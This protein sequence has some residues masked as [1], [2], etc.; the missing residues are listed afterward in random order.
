MKVKSECGDQQQQLPCRGYILGT[1]LNSLVCSHN[2]PEALDGES[3][4]MEKDREDSLDADESQNE[5]LEMKD[6]LQELRAIQDEEQSWE[7]WT[8][9]YCQPS[10]F[11]DL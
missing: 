10:K 8:L 1:I 7:K 2:L 11:D 5:E 4:N 6:L 9:K 3:G